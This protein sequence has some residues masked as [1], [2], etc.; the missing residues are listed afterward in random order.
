MPYCWNQEPKKQEWAWQVLGTCFVQSYSTS[1]GI[2]CLHRIHVVLS[3]FCISWTCH[4]RIMRPP[5]RRKWCGTHLGDIITCFQIIVF[6]VL[7][8]N[9]LL[10]LLPLNP[11][12][13]A[14][15]GPVSSRSQTCR[16]GA[17]S[18]SVCNCQTSKAS[19]AG[20][21]K[22]F[23]DLTLVT[24]YFDANKVLGIQWYLANIEW[25]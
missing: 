1:L 16:V 4:S 14:R 3:P 24:A 6:S 11:C 20:L 8:S 13:V 18:S 9:C 10:P 23:M 12:T 22:Y 7:W 21:C 25:L 15:Q 2:G 5:W 19:C 17:L